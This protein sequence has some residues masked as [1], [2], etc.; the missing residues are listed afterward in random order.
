MNLNHN[1]D[2]PSPEVLR[3]TPLA[4]ALYTTYCS[5]VGGRAYNGDQLPCADDFFNDAA[6][7]VQVKA[8]IDVA[9]TARCI[10]Q[11]LKD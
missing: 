4:K 11:T 3:N 6:K 5:S 10:L 9:A 8:W 1:I 7:T 2:S